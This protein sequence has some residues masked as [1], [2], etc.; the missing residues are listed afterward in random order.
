[1]NLDE[2]RGLKGQVVTFRLL[3]NAPGAPVVTGRGTT[4]P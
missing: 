3:P 4:R 1:M 2:I